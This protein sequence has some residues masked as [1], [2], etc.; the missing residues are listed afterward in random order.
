MEDS[1]ANILFSPD[2]ASV[3]KSIHFRLP[4][5]YG[6]EFVQKWRFLG[7]IYIHWQPNF[8]LWKVSNG[9]P[10]IML[11]IS[12]SIQLLLNWSK[13][14]SRE[15]QINGFFNHCCPIFC[16]ITICLFFFV[17]LQYVYFFLICKI[18]RTQVQKA[19]NLAIAANRDN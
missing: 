16:I 5:Q 11:P 3:I 18:L 13:T 14:L 10:L 17:L 1:L 6:V 2:I 12:K 4:G 19:H 7:E 9:V 15:K 8:L